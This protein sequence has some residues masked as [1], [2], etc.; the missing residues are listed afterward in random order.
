M[1]DR[2]Q[3]A[4]E[5]LLLVAVGLAILVVAVSLVLQLRGISDTVAASVRS[6]RAEAIAMLVR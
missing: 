5:Y 4:T 3:A 1:D 6:E 2:A